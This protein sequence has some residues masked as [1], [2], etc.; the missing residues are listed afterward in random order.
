MHMT[1]KH[2]WVCVNTGNDLFILDT[3]DYRLYWQLAGISSKN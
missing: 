3:Y 1:L 2:F